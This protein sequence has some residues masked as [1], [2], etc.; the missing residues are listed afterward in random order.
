MDQVYN[1][2]PKFKKRQS[3]VTAGWRSARIF[4]AFSKFL[5]DRPKKATI[6]KNNTMSK[7]ARN[8]IFD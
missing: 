8:V 6:I 4:L 1:T 2:S 7:F 5:I 3:P